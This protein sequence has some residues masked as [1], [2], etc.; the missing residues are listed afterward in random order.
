MLELEKRLFVF[1]NKAIWF[2]EEPFDVRGYD[3]VNFFYCK[4][5]TELP[6]FYCFPSFTLILDLSLGSESVFKNFSH[7]LRNH[8][9]RAQEIPVEIDVNRNY[10]EFVEINQTFR[11]KKGLKGL[12][13]SSEYIKQ[14]GILFT[15]KICNDVVS[16]LF[17]LKD[18]NTIRGL[19]QASKRLDV[20]K[21]KAALIGYANKLLWWEAIMYSIN[22]GIKEFDFGGYY[23]GDDKADAMAGINFYKTGF[24][25]RL[26]DRYD[27]YKVYSLKY[28][29]AKRLFNVFAKMRELEI[30]LN[31]SIEKVARKW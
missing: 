19:V 17:L 11:K 8:I 26:I 1:K 7:T 12:N 22:K 21:E 9:R 23:V 3:T 31:L 20:D 13:L 6:G 4:T 24:G 30:Y 16:G 2:A 14:T 27:Y 18:E 10:K 29:I 5:K 15:A 25:G 28:T